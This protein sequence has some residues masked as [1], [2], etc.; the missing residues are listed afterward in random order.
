MIIN[1]N[2][3]GV[4]IMGNNNHLSLLV[5]NKASH[6]VETIFDDYWLLARGF[7]FAFCLLLCLGCE[8]GFLLGLGLRAILMKQSEQLG[9]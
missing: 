6:M 2:L 3:N 9:S 1:T 5:L 8:S 7:F 4:N